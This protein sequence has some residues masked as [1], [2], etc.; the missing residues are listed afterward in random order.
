MPLQLPETILS[1]AEQEIVDREKRLVEANEIYH[2]GGIPVMTDYSYDREWRSHELSRREYPHFFDPSSPR[3]LFADGGTI[4]DK[5]GATP[6]TDGFT[7]VRHGN[8]MLSIND[9]FEGDGVAQYEELLTFV[10]DMEKRLGNGA[11]PMTVEPKVDGCALKLIYSYGQLTLA[12][13]RGDGEFGDDITDN[14]RISGIVPQSIR[15]DEPWDGTMAHPLNSDFLEVVGE[16]YMPVDAFVAANKEREE[17]GLQLWA[18]PR[19]AAAGAIKLQDEAE[20][21]KRPLAFIRHDG[22]V[23]PIPSIQTT[24]VFTAYNW[25]QLIKSVEYVRGMKLNYATDGAVVKLADLW[26]RATVGTGTRAPNWACAFKFKPVQVET[27]LLDI[28]VQVGRT[29]VLTPVAVLEPVHVDGTTVSSATLHNED[30]IRSLGLRIGDTVI[31]QKAGAIIPQIVGSVEH[32]KR[33]AE[34]MEWSKASFSNT[35]EGHEAR[36]EDALEKERPPF[37]LI[38]H[39]DHKCPCCQGPVAKSIAIGEENEVAR[40]CENPGCQAQ[41]AAKIKHAASRKCLDIE[42]VGEEVAD[43]LARDL[44]Q[45]HT[46]F[47]IIRRMV[48]GAL[49]PELSAL[50]L[51]G[52][53]RSVTFGESNATKAVEAA[54]RA[55]NMPMHRWLWALGIRTIGENTAK[56]ISRLYASPEELSLIDPDVDVGDVSDGD[57]CRL[58][59]IAQ[60]AEGADKTQPPYAQFNVSSHLGPVS[61]NRLL[62][63]VQSA[64]GQRILLQLQAWGIKSDRFDPVP[65]VSDEKPLVGKTFV[66]TG[67]LS[68]GRDEMKALIE[69][70]GG[71][72]SGSVSAKTNYLVAGEGGGG[73]ADKARKL[74]VEIIDEAAVRLMMGGGQ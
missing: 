33:Y 22:I 66:I 38:A 40:R 32:Q 44:G 64:E 46:A 73:K 24:P 19:N 23:P 11:W 28:A 8:P 12:V 17:D 55:V 60:I 25:E 56:E 62:N 3:Y 69:S 41:M 21:R 52:S 63:F 20:L 58:N 65:Q 51:T 10:R 6:K 9:V 27:K 54:K 42:G 37:D 43:A 59:L 29:G 2:H 53:G 68:V 5:V 35:Q 67:T 36:V 45:T 50:Q 26:V 70:K 47:D 74:G 49:L 7:K 16:V 34:L 57:A 18:N 31:L 48:S 1:S 14:V 13:T 4:L 15:P 61:C 71:K 30:H 39:V 72:V